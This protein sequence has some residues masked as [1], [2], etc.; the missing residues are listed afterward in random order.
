MTASLGATVTS[1]ASAD[2]DELLQQADAAM[3]AAKRAGGDRF[4]MYNAELHR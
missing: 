3:Y 1:D 4:Q 2:P